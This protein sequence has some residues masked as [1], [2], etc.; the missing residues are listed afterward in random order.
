MPA[1]TACHVHASLVLLYGSMALGAWLGVGEDPVQVFTLS[2]VL[3]DPLAHRVT[4]HLSRTES[5]IRQQY[6]RTVSH[7]Q[8]LP[9]QPTV[10]SEE[11]K[12][13]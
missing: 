6:R 7:K 13:H 5:A 4:R 10:G 11:A 12:T 9:T 8:L 1:L 2:T 3:G